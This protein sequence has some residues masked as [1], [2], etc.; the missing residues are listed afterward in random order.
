[1]PCLPCEAEPV[2]LPAAASTHQPHSHAINP[3]SKA[4]PAA[5]SGLGSFV[6]AGTQP[7]APSNVLPAN[8]AT[9]SAVKPE[10]SQKQA[11][12]LHQPINEDTGAANQQEAALNNADLMVTEGPSTTQGTAQHP[13]AKPALA[14]E[15]AADAQPPIGPTVPAEAPERLSA[16]S[17]MGKRASG[18]GKGGNTA[19]PSKRRRSELEALTSGLVEQQIQDDGAPG[20][21]ESASG[22]TSRRTRGIQVSASSSTAHPVGPSCKPCWKSFRESVSARCIQMLSS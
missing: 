2:P 21:P 10:S 15:Q 20:N 4:A 11:E 8:V 14:E 13:K 9:D 7:A 17:G 18:A 5:G 1:M 12:A 6:E 22:S 19:R 3:A 16:A